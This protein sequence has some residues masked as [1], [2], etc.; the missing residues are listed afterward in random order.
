MLSLSFARP[1]VTQCLCVSLGVTKV[2]DRNQVVGANPCAGAVSEC[3]GPGY[4]SPR[5]PQVIVVAI[6]EYFGT[7]RCR[8]ALISAVWSPPRRPRES[9]PLGLRGL[10]WARDD[11]ALP[12]LRLALDDEE[13]RAREMALKVIS[14]HLLGVFIPDA[15]A[16]SDD[17]V[18]RVRQAARR[19]LTQLAAGEPEHASRSRVQYPGIGC[20]C[21]RRKGVRGGS[22]P[23]PSQ[24]AADPLVPR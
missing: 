6:A 2:I 16:A 14:R 18:P 9:A 5:R 7:P 20:L 11:T 13:W 8:A 23:G 17:P 19:A 22:L 15:A 24:M 4:K 12:E 3:I 10:L 1:G 21:R